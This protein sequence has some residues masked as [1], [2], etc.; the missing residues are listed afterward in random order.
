LEKKKKDKHV[1]SLEERKKNDHQQQIAHHPLPRN[2]L[3]K[4][5]H[6]N[7]FKNIVKWQV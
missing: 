6:N 5:G 4:R 7:N 1:L 2:T 3:A